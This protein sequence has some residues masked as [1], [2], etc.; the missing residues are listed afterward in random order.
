MH[1]SQKIL[2]LIAASSM[3][4]S[5]GCSETVL[6]VNPGSTPPTRV[7]AMASTRV[8]GVEPGLTKSTVSEQPIETSIEEA[9][10]RERIF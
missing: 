9:A 5:M 6:F 8:G 3:L 10:M 4:V 2:S 1:V 7:D